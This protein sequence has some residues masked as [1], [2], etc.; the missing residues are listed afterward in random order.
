MTQAQSSTARKLKWIAFLAVD[1]ALAVALFFLF[2]TRQELQLHEELNDLGTT[3]YPQQIDV[4]D[5]FSLLTHYGETFTADHLRGRWSLVFFGFTNCPNICPLSMVE[6][7]Q[8]YRTLEESAADNGEK[9]LVVMVT[10]DPEQDDP[11]TLADYVDNY[12]DDFIGLTGRP[13]Q[14]RAFAEQLYVVIDEIEAEAT[15]MAMHTGHGDGD[16]DAEQPAAMAGHEA[17]GQSPS[18]F[19]HSGHISVISPDG[20]LYAVMRLPHRDQYINTA[21]QLL[22]DNWN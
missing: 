19:D 14:I 6:L 7:G 16:A 17:H 21:Y 12:H 22:L 1:A 3:I 9:P 8:F 5:D 2:T 11:M 18:G 15:E 20:K 13:D 4:A 10:V